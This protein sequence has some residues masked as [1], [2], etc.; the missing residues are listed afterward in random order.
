[1][2]QLFQG[3]SET[4]QQSYILFEQDGKSLVSVTAVLN[5]FHPSLSQCD[6]SAVDHNVV[7]A[8]ISSAVTCII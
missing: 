6:L 1:M 5:H 3:L 8:K 7:N 4:V 2:E